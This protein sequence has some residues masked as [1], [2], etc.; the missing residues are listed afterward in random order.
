MR[1]GRFSWGL[2]LCCGL[3]IAGGC[4][5]EQIV[6]P[7]ES[8]A[9]KTAAPEPPPVPKTVPAPEAQTPTPPPKPVMKDADE[10]AARAAAE[11]KEAQSAEAKAADAKALLTL[12][13]IYF[14]FDSSDISEASRATLKKSHALLTKNSGVKVQVEGHC[15]ERGSDE[16]NLAL[17][18][19]RAKAAMNYLV[20]LG[21]KPARLSAISYGKEK[22]VDPGHTEEAWAKNRRAE[23]VIVK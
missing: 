18:D 9:A 20:T 12:D 17:G 23:F 22:P 13:N 15:D 19:R 5:K 21:V 10:S 2:A 11:A 3:L 16:Y 1:T 14:D 8:I 7:E 6:K 4:A